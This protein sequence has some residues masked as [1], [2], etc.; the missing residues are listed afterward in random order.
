MISTNISESLIDWILIEQGTN[1][2]IDYL[3]LLNNTMIKKAA[4]SKLKMLEGVNGY[5]QDC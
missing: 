1:Q 2:R 4:Q 5:L 3:Y